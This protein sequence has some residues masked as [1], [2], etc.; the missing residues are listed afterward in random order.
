MYKFMIYH[1]AAVSQN[2]CSGQLNEHGKR[3][4]EQLVSMFYAKIILK[5]EKEK[6][7]KKNMF[8]LCWV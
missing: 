6:E 1:K 3:R 5:N 7:R 4:K 8:V 2:E